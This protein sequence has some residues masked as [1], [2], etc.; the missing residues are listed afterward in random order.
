MQ[1]CMNPP[2]QNMPCI[3]ITVDGVDKL[4]RCLNLN[5]AQGPDEISPRVLKEL[6]TKIVPIPIFRLSL[7]TRIVPVDWKNADIAPLFKKSN[8]LIQQ[9]QTDIH[10]LYKSMELITVSNWM[11]Y[12]DEHNILSPYNMVLGLKVVAKLSLRSVCQPRQWTTDRHHCDWFFKGLRQ[13]WPSQ[14]TN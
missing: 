1:T 5:K 6:Q 4:L 9:L 13:S 12:F 2:P 14:Y 3:T 8:N 11:T 10:H 7:E